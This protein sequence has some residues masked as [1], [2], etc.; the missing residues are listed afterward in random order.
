VS[1]LLQVSKFDKRDKLFEILKEHGSSFKTVVFVETKRNA[2]FMATWL[3]NEGLPTTSIHGDR[4]QREREEALADFQSGR[5]SILVA[6][7][8]RIVVPRVSHVVNYDLPKDSTEY[9]RRVK[10]IWGWGTMVTMVI[11][12]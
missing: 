7:D 9:C 5:M 1:F 2:D 11:P 12:R 8:V 4:L 6:T 10:I 3:S